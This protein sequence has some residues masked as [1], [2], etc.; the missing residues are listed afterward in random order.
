MKLLALIGYVAIVWLIYS[1][2]TQ[3]KPTEAE[4]FGCEH[5]YINARG[6]D[7]GECN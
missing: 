4:K 6:E 5:T 3:H 7:T 2:V 1:Y